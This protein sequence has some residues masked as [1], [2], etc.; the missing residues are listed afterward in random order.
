MELLLGGPRVASRWALAAIGGQCDTNVMKIEFEL[1]SAQAARLKTLASR[2]R[3]P[4][5]RL[6]SAAV[7]DLIAESSEEFE[8]AAERVLDKNKELYKRLS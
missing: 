3:V 4:I 2:L 6:A 7:A 1:T 5:H 8:S